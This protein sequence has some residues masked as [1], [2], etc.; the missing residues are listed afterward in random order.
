MGTSSQWAR[1]LLG[2]AAASPEGS[3]ASHK[4]FVPEQCPFS[5]TELP[6]GVEAVATLMGDLLLSCSP[7]LSVVWQKTG[8]ARCWGLMGGSGQGALE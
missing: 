2:S 1:E 6:A 4:S 3:C 5:M 8:R 7:K